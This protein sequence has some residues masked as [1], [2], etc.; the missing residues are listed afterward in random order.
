MVAN[1]QHPSKADNE[2]VMRFSDRY[3]EVSE[4]QLRKTSSPIVFTVDGSVTE[5]ND[6]HSWKTPHSR[7]AMS[8]IVI[9]VNEQQPWKVQRPRVLILGGIVIEVREVQSL[10]T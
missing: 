7:V 5:V 4:E 2:I 10:K 3:T 1:L 6:L 8:G 9:E